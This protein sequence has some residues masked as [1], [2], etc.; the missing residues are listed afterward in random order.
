MNS[1]QIRPGYPLAV[2][3]SV[4]NRKLHVKA[5]PALAKETEEEVEELGNVVEDVD[6]VR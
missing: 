2:T 1:H 4:N 6:K 5:M 3:R